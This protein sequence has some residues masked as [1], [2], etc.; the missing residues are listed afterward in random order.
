MGPAVPAHAATV[1]LGDAATSRPQPVGLTCSS[2]T[3]TPLVNTATGQ[4]GRP[5]RVG[6]G[7]R[8]HPSWPVATVLPVDGP[9][10][11]TKAGSPQLPMWFC[12]ENL[13]LS[14]IQI[15]ALPSLKVV[16]F[17]SW[18]ALGKL[19]TLSETHFPHHDN[20]GDVANLAGQVWTLEKL[21]VKAPRTRTTAL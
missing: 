12:E 7:G 14:W 9:N 13:R 19:L 21:N 3:S 15:A 1:P 8:H 10:P 6:G 18:V 17:E 16:A 11:Y 2:V 20:K 5:V 4:R